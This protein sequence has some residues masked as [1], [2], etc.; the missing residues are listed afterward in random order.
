M[1]TVMKL[2]RRTYALLKASG[3]TRKITT[4]PGG[5]VTVVGDLH[6]QLSDL[7]HILDEC[8]MP[9][10]TNKYVF[11]GDFV[12][13]GENGVEITCILMSL[14]LMEPENIVLNRG[15]H[16]DA[17]ITRVYGFQDEC[18]NKYDELTYGMFSEVFR[19]LPL[20]VLIDEVIFIV[21]GGLFNN[22]AVTLADLDKISRIDYVARPPISYPQC[23][24]GEKCIVCV[25]IDICVYIEYICIV[26]MYS[27]FI[28]RIHCIHVYVVYTC[29]VY[30]ICLP[31][32][33]LITGFY[34]HKNILVLLSIYTNTLNILMYAYTQVLTMTASGSSTTSSCRGTRCG[35]IRSSSRV[36]SIVCIYTVYVYGVCRHAIF[37]HIHSMCILNVCMCILKICS[38]RHTNCHIYPPL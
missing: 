10:K 26:Y 24:E 25:Y 34:M 23:L 27:V 33:I 22:R 12:D 29:D 11:N 2:L 36:S 4:P 9:S 8:G 14:F 28:K 16:E 6:G 13:R 37:S 3:N 1:N 7:L 19:Y 15:N 20:F 18:I 31:H 32:Y 35:A 38:I 30:A 21:H 17:A 5:K